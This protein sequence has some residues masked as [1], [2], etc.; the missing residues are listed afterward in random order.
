MGLWFQIFKFQTQIGTDILI[1]QVNITLDWIPKDLIDG[2]SNWFRWWLG[3]IR[4]KAITWISVNQ[5]LLCLTASLGHINS[6]C[7]VTP[8][9]NIDLGQYWLRLWL[10]VW[11]HLAITWINVDYTQVR[12]C[13]ILLRAIAQDTILFKKFTFEITAISQGPTS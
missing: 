4:Q 9:G 5:D 10:I 11:W 3:A 12:F 7:I 2:K 8:S 13:G 1:I 6:L